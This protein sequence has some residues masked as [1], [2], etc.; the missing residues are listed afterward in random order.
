MNNTVTLTD[1]NGKK[2][3]V[4]CDSAIMTI[5][6]EGTIFGMSLRTIMALRIEYL[7][8]GGAKPI[9]EHT[10]RELFKKALT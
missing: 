6:G 7:K 5:I 4:L 1:I 10:V 9:T 3:D 2:F 8:R